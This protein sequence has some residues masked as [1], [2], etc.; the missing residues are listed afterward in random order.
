MGVVMESQ[1]YAIIGPDKKAL[2]FVL[3]DGVTDYDYG[4]ANG[5]EAILILEGMRYGFGWEWD[6][7]QF[8]DPSLTITQ[9]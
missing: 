9:E 5:N 6:G 1:T 8:I 3:W 4:Q 7:T 2:N